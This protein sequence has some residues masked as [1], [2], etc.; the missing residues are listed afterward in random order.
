MKGIFTAMVVICLVVFVFQAGSLNAARKGGGIKVS[1]TDIDCGTSTKETNNLTG[2]NR[3]RVWVLATG[4]NRITKYYRITC[5]GGASTAC[6]DIRLSACGASDPNYYENDF[7]LINTSGKDR[8][9]FTLY[10]DA[11][12]Q[13]SS[14][15][16]S[17]RQ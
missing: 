7:R 4:G 8:C 1:S 17:W 9:T 2:E 16:D 5:K 12:C 14:S 3:A 15:S 11:N 6:D 10:G 13:S